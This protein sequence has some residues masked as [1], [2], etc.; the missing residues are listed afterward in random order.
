MEVLVIAAIIVIFIIYIVISNRPVY[1]YKKKNLLTKT[2][3]AF[4]KILKE[5][6]D[7]RNYLICPKV[8][9]E[10]FLE[11]TNEEEK[12]KYR[13]YIKSRHIDFI[14]CDED[15]HMLCGMELDDYTHNF[16]NAQK[17]DRFK[18]EVFKTIDLPLY[19]IQVGDDSYREQLK[20][21]FH[22]LRK[23]Y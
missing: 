15:L 3:Y 5:E 2:E 14:I 20:N 17:I 6:C 1:P 4:Y 12:M 18:N 23:K 9:M 16:K 19:R 11:V 8:R 13:G 10:D 22:E 21:V 7:K